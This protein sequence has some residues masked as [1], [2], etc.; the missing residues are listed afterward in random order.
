MLVN[1]SPVGEADSHVSFFSA[2]DGAVT[3]LARGLRKPASK[4]AAS[5]LPA[6][7][8][9]VR[10]AEGRGR[11]KILTGVTITR[12]HAEWRA[13]LDLLALYWFMAECLYLS[14]GEPEINAAMYRLVV[15]MLRST[16]AVAARYSAVAVY[17]LKLQKLHGLLPDLA[18]CALDGH[19]LADD[20]PVHLLPSGEGI[21][22]RE[23]YNRHYARTGGG[24]IRLEAERLRRWRRLLSG[25]LLDYPQVP[26]DEID[27]ALLVYHLARAVGDIAGRSLNSAAYMRTQWK[28]PDISELLQAQL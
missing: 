27:V 17:A 19:S 11:R 20:E 28:L 3:A 21:I 25:A 22:G 24:L 26:A 12:S 23:A 1:I 13:E 16:P 9:N 5:L 7:E 15:N 18:H 2:G 6:D 14:A 10:L 4:L 8:L